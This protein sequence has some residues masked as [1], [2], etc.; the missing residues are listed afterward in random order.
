MTRRLTLLNVDILKAEFPL[1]ITETPDEDVFYSACAE[2]TEASHVPWTLLSAGITFEDF[3]R[4]V[5]VA[6]L[7]GAS[8]VIT[9]RAVWK[10]AIELENKKDASLTG[11]A[12]ERLI[13]L[14]DLVT[15]SVYPWIINQFPNQTD[16]WYRDY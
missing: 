15:S 14:T 16:G 11:L 6:C 8:G 5:N 2:L 7:S 9:G 10:E 12:Q 3:P 1:E 13:Q 4:Q